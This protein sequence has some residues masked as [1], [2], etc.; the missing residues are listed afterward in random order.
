MLLCIDCGN[1][2]IKWGFHDGQVWLVQGVLGVNEVDRLAQVF[3]GQPRPARAVACN[4]ASEMTGAAVE[5]IVNELG[6]SLLW[7]KSSAEQCGVTNSYDD[8]TQLGADRWAALIGA[9]QVHGG[10]CLVVNAGTATTI[11]ILDGEGVFQG[12]LI[13]P[14]INLMRSA[15]AS[16]TARLPFASGHFSLLPRNTA[17]AIVSGSLLATTGAIT[18]MFEHIA[19]TPG[20]K[21]LLSGG[22]AGFLK[23]LLNMPLHHVDNLVLE[24]LACIIVQAK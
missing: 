22:A 2:R 10:A 1:T 7:V 4:V 19:P 12:G 6:L 17:D 13:L 11:D 23:P 24:G 5:A 8:P 14:G 15:L 18:R 21:C 20:A 3:A 9:K 16:D